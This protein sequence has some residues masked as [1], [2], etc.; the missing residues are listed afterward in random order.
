MKLLKSLTIVAV[1]SLSSTALWAHEVEV[2][3]GEKL[4]YVSHDEVQEEFER[5][6]AEKQAEELE[7]QKAAAEKRQAELRRERF[8]N[9]M[10]RER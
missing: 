1:S 5:L 6:T 4:N 10:S 9:R 2:Q 7:A 3:K 8:F